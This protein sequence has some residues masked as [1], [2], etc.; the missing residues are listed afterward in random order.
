MDSHLT[1]DLEDTWENALWVSFITPCH[2]LLVPLLTGQPFGRLFV[3]LL[4]SYLL[5]LLLDTIQEVNENIMILGNRL[6]L[7]S[8]EAEEIPLGFLFSSQ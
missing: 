6:F 3:G 4:P 2:C 1:F 5:L 7:H 8:G